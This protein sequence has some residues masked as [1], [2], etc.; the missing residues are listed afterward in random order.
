MSTTQAP[1]YWTRTT[2]FLSWTPVPNAM[3]RPVYVSQV[4]LAELDVI[5]AHDESGATWGVSINDELAADE[6]PSALS[7]QIV[8][9]G[10][11]I[12]HLTDMAGDAAAPAVAD[13][14]KRARAL[15]EELHALTRLD[16]GNLSQRA[17]E[18]L[19]PYAIADTEGDDQ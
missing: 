11:V 10:L 16:S 12:E 7:A 5:V 14:E 4:D 19:W 9:M 13:Q 2:G 1:A 17:R 3:D 6:Y 15:L 18:R 8:A